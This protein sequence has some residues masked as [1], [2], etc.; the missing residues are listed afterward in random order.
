VNQPRHITCIVAALLVLILSAVS[1]AAWADVVTDWN[2]TGVAATVAAGLPGLAQSRAMAVVHAAVYD[3]VNSIERRHA[4]YAADIKAPAG[5]SRE[6]AAATAAYTVLSRLFWTQIPVFDVALEASLAGIPDGQSKS[7][8]TAVGRE[9]AEKILA[10][11]AT[12]GANVSATYAYRTGPAMY[13]ATPPANVSPIMPHWGSVQP[14]TL[15]ASSQFAVKGPTPYNSPEFARDFAEVKLMGAKKSTARTKDQTDIARFWMISGIVTDNS[16]ARQVAMKKGSS[17][18]ENARI[19]ALLNMAGADA[20]IACWEAKYRLHHWR[21][22]T[23]IRNAA[24]TGNP[25]LVADPNW[26]PLLVTPAHPEYPSGHTCY[27]GATER[28]L[29]EMFGDDNSFTLTF[30]AMK[31]TRTYQTF[32]QLGKEVIDA[33]VWAG[34]H[35]RTTD[36][37]GYDLG[38]RVAEHALQNVLRPLP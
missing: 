34:I 4:P 25:A 27:A 10:L 1:P 36:E 18:A 33:R 37:D 21:P 6:A 2:E 15:K 12:D 3:A 35:Y 20:Y 26:E 17:V 24:S 22:I 9:A 29:Q 13:Q 23:A 31:L 19:F 5:A 8:G 14:F 30:P 16:A 28:V 32:S 38:R 7:D 11:R